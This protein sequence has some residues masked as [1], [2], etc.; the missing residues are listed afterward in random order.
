MSSVAY[1][2]HGH[3][4]LW[5]QPLVLLHSLSDSLIAIAYFSIPLA[6]IYLIQRRCDIPY[7]SI[8]W[9]FSAFIV[10][11]G[12]THVMAIWTLWHPAYWLSGAIKALTAIIS[13][14]AVITLV[15]ILPQAIAL[16]SP[17]EL[18][19]LNQKL[20]QQIIERRQVEKQLEHIALYDSLTQL[21]NRA[22]FL[23]RL[24]QAVARAQRTP[25]FSF[26]VMLLDVDRFKMINDTLGHLLGDQLLCQIAARPKTALRAVDTIARLGGDEF[27]IL[28]EEVDSPAAARRI[29]EKLLKAFQLP[30]QLEDH[31]LLITTSIG[32]TFS[33]TPFD[34]SSD[35]LR[36]ADAA[37]YRSKAQRHGGYAVFDATMHSQ[38]KQLMQLEQ[39]L[40]RAVA[41]NELKVYYHPIVALAT[42]Q[43]VSLEALVRWEKPGEGLVCSAQ[44][45]PIAE[46]IGLIGSIDRQVLQAA[47]SQL[48][49]WQQL[50]NSGADW[51]EG[52]QLI[53]GIDSLALAININL[54]AKQ[55]AQTGLPESFEHILQKHNLSGRC[56]KIEVTESA[57]IEDAA[58]ADKI[59]SQIKSLG[60]QICLDDFGTGYSALGYLHRFPIDIVKIDCSFIQGME[61]E[62][63]KLEIV[64]ATIQLCHALGVKVT[65]EGIETHRQQ[66]ILADLGCEYGQGYLFAQPLS[67][68]AVTQLLRG[69]PTQPY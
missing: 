63:E 27:V 45:I 50:D 42:R 2:P 58:R 40:R 21:P 48:K 33:S 19:A 3:C 60:V 26:A 56:L 52:T 66:K 25:D 6:L 18:Q 10:S 61:A 65:A 22:L 43:V 28:L 37:M 14:Y 68:A 8:F 15:P 7:R 4:Y 59:L 51:L 67:S 12:V 30:F 24:E 55:F 29:A 36:N 62:P 41:C 57:L 64:R 23:S 34:R 47:C 39:D 13:L 53:P 46:E 9:L 16:P 11:C 1:I 32:V 35:L 49:A 44:F 5:Q 20:Q 69:K 38:A 54:S 17:A 31:Q